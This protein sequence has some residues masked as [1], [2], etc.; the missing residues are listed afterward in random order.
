M[1]VCTNSAPLL[2]WSKIHIILQ[3]S[4]LPAHILAPSDDSHVI[5]ACAAPGN[6]TTHLSSIMH[7]RGYVSIVDLC[8]HVRA[9]C[10]LHVATVN[11]YCVLYRLIYAFDRDPKRYEILGDMVTRGGASNVILQL[12]DFLTVGPCM[13]TQ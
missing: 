3:A 9:H 13:C 12:A 10:C 2:T 11:N 7:N 1:Y 8:V 4:C 5:D 6:K